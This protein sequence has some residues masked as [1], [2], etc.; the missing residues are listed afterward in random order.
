MEDSSVFSPFK[1]LAEVFQHYFGDDREK[2][3]SQAIHR[4]IHGGFDDLL[5]EHEQMYP[6]KRENMV[7]GIDDLTTVSPSGDIKVWYRGFYDDP[8]FVELPT[9]IVWRVMRELQLRKQLTKHLGPEEKV[10]EV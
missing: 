1:S 6:P 7:V 10:V 3:L 9:L 5:L 4:I 8:T 2:F